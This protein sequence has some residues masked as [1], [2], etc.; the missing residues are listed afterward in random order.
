MSNE[1]SLDKSGIVSYQKL[2]AFI[3][4]IGI[5][6]PFLTW[7]GCLITGAGENA[8]QHSIS[9]YYYTKMH[10]V[11][12]GCLCILGG[13]L[14]TYEGR[15]TGESRLSNIAGCFAFGIA[16]FPTSFCGFQPPSNGSNQYLF[17]TVNV[18]A[19]LGALH[20]VFAG[21]LFV[22]FAIFCFIYFPIPDAEYIGIDAIKFL[23]RKRIYKICGYGIIVSILMIAFFSFIFQPEKGVFVYSTFIFETTALLSFGIAWLVKGSMVLKG[24]PIIK[25]VVKKIR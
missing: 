4:F 14:I 19:Q 8:L 2:R 20:F 6:L 24:V 3:G 10:I 25:K 18:N 21:L 11:F 5:L 17:L 23:K 13:F 1:H 22:C 12:I 15:Q 9:H 7:F 16:A